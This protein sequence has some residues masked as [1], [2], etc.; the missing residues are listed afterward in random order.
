VAEFKIPC[1]DI[2]AHIL[3]IAKDMDSRAN[4]AIEEFLTLLSVCHTVIPEINEKGNIRYQVC[5]FFYFNQIKIQRKEKEEKMAKEKT[6]YCILFNTFLKAA[7][8]DEGALVEATRNFG[9]FFHTRNPKDVICDIRGKRQRFEILAVLE[10]NSTRKRMSVVCRNAEDGV[11]RLFCKGADSVIMERMKLGISSTE[12][13]RNRTAKKPT[14][15]EIE[16]EEL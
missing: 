6:K 10:F 7:S 15:T 9:F 3:L 12:K 14:I 11:I 13:V 2:P 16:L 4:P 1:S 5:P 8:P